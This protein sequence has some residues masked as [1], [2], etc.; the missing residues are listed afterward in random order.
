MS[1]FGSRITRWLTLTTATVLSACVTPPRGEPPA[2]APIE[3]SS[4]GLNGQAVQPVDSSWYQSFGDQQL[5][6]LITQ[7]LQNNPGL[8]EVATRL[9]EAQAQAS[10][11]RAARFPSAKLSGGETHLKI[12]SGFPPALDAGHT[13]WAGDLGASLAWDLDLWGKHADAFAQAIAL[14][15]AAGL[16]LDSARVLLT[17]SVVQT[18]IDLNRAYLRA[19][20]AERTEAQRSNILDITKQ[21][22]AAGLDTRV[23][24]RQAEAQLLQARVALQQAQSAQA[25]AAHELAALLGRGAADYAGITRPTLDLQAGLP[26]PTALPINLLSRRPDVIA[27]RE[28][29]DAADA[30]RRAAKAAFYPTVN[31]SAFAGFASFSLTD[32][33]SSPSFGYGAG[34]A[35]SLP[36]FDADRL[37]AQYRGTQAQ[38]DGAVVAYD[39]TVVRAVHQAADQLTL[40][41]ALAGELELQRQSLAASEDAYRLA[42]ERYRAGL[43]GYLTVLDVETEVLN[44]REQRVDLS[45]SLALARVTLLLAVGGSFQNPNPISAAAR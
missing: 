16:D 1:Q 36:L 44:E 21:R 20:I 19:D 18:Y 45:H 33:I 15:R 2:L 30:G 24:L 38:L 12:P 34:P 42:E 6:R 37:R 22:V 26:L 27:A 4:L 10:E 41:D 5:N 31:L 13:V 40:I 17:G 35:V 32:L 11:A 9:R 23:E 8:I 28:R 29:I 3:P 25:L 14:S 7:A 43:A 39:E